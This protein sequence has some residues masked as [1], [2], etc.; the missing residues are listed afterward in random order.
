MPKS[1]QDEKMDSIPTWADNFKK[2]MS[3]I[4]KETMEKQM[5]SM[6]DKSM[7]QFRADLQKS[8][9]WTEEEIKETKTKVNKLENDVER[10]DLKLGQIRAKLRKSDDRM[11]HLETMQ[12]RNNLVFSGFPEKEGENQHDIKQKLRELFEIDMNLT[13]V[14]EISID[15]C[16][17]IAS[18]GKSESTRARD[19]IVRF[20]LLSDKHRVLGS[21]KQLKGRE[22]PIYINEQYRIFNANYAYSGLY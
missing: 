15:T 13:C 9:A 1:K 19:I 2:E 18:R 22:P 17:R 7:K 10:H 5:K 12:M 6:L 14:D 3:Q 16:H 21:A 4:I 11:D 8:L 20:S